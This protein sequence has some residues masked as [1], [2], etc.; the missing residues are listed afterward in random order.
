MN[1][2]DYIYRAMLAM[3]KDPLV[4]LNRQEPL[5]V[6]HLKTRSLTLEEVQ[7]WCDA[8]GY[9]E[10]YSAGG[11][12]FAFPKGDLQSWQINPRAGVDADSWL[13]NL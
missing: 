7:D 4:K 2:F 3:C 5:P 11:N 13:A 8:H 1:R 9:T 12:W 6:I 10:P